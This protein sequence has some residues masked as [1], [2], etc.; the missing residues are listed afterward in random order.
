[1]SSSTYNTHFSIHRF[2]GYPITKLEISY[3]IGYTHN[4]KLNH[5]HNGL[6]SLAV[7]NHNVLNNLFFMPKMI[8]DAAREFDEHT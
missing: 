8:F 7:Y 1:M 4:S 3:F 5:L 2:A 6:N